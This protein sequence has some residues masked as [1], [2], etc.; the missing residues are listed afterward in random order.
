MFRRVVWNIKSSA[1]RHI[2]NL[3]QQTAIIIEQWFV[4]V[5]NLINKYRCHENSI[6]HSSEVRPCVHPNRNKHKDL[7]VC[8]ALII[9]D[10][11]WLLFLSVSMPQTMPTSTSYSFLYLLL[12]LFFFFSFLTF[13]EED[14]MVAGG[15]ENKSHPSLFI[16]HEKDT[17]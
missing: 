1:S 8:E 2:C 4:H 11:L 3:F 12:T 6:C 7:R 15:D 10:K 5:T 13:R 14:K 17:Q 9:S 16:R